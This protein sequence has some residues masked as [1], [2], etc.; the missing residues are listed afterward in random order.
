MDREAA[1]FRSG[2]RS[3]DDPAM[4]RLSSIVVLILC[5]ASA[6]RPEHLEEI[7][8]ISESGGGFNHL[9]Q[10]VSI[11]A[12][13]GTL[14]PER[15]IVQRIRTDTTGCGTKSP[16]G[17]CREL[18]VHSRDWIDSDSCSA[19]VPALDAL[20][21]LQVPSFAGSS[22]ITE[23]WSDHAT[24]LTIIGRP[25]SVKSATVPRFGRTTT[26][27][28]MI[29]EQFG[30]FHEWWEKTEEALNGCW[31]EAAPDIAGKPAEIELRIAP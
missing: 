30:I 8:R 15:W 5:A 23:F 16:E 10:T 22:G 29:R 20:A 17:H 28:V 27:L 2:D 26:A 31:R 21:G 12:V 7:Y 1:A 18:V 14:N 25:K 13:N 9:E 11:A 24:E 19:L 3:L 4:R 6:P